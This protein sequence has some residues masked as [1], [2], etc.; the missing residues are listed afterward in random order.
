MPNSLGADSARTFAAGTTCAALILESAA[1]H[2]D[3]DAIVLPGDRVT[4]REWAAG[5]AEWSRVL[6]ALG[7]MQG[8]HVGILLP[9]GTEF[10]QV[11]FGA[12]LAG[13]VPV[14]I[15][16][17]YRGPELAAMLADAELVTVVTTN[18]VEYRPSL[19][20][21]LHEALPELSAAGVPERQL[22]GERLSLA[23]APCLR[24]IISTQGPSSPRILERRAAAASAAGI[25]SE[26]IENRRRSVQPED[27]ALILYTSGSTARPKGCLL[28]HAAIVAQGR[29]LAGRYQ[30]T[31]RDRIWSP[32]PM[33]HVGGI[34]PL[35]AIASVGGA[36]L[37]MRR[38]EAGPG[39]CDDGERAS[40]D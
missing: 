23:Q 18:D 32:L 21:R 8:D 12:M 13:A 1:A 35:M 27:T 4:Y 7:V 20:E 19:I 6:I 33:F 5:A 31:A 10:M 38:I 40:H 14:P 36:Y 15:N 22:P 37:S 30:M 29:L 39:T 9:N 2:A 25:P 3:A 11:L 34:S 28:S 17:R 26:E 16:A 24:S